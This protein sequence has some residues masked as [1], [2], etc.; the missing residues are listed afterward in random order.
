MSINNAECESCLELSN[1]T[2]R[3]IIVNT[4][5][6][7]PAG[8]I[9]PFKEYLKSVLSKLK[10]SNKQL[11]LIGDFNLNLLDYSTNTKVKNFI[12]LLFQHGLMPLINKPT[13]VTRR[14][15][16]LIDLIITNQFHNSLCTTGIIKTQISDH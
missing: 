12:N 16:T 4:F 2:T 14:S 7:Q 8:K 15:A 3:N 9:K 11:Y 13:R 1:G 10:N 6:R 5:Y